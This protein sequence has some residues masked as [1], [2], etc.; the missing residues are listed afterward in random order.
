[1]KSE[2]E[3]FSRKQHCRVPRLSLMRYTHSGESFASEFAANVS[4]RTTF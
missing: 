4:R 2:R 1:M 3:A